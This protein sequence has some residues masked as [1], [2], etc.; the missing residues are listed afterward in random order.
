[1]FRSVSRIVR[2]GAGH[3]ILADKRSRKKRFDNQFILNEL[4]MCAELKSSSC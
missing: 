1:M 4:Y 3:A 2:Y